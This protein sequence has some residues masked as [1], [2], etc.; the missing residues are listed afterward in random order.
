M[1]KSSFIVGISGG[2]GSGKTCFVRDLKNNLGSENICFISLDNYYLP[3][4]EQKT[5]DQGIKNFDL[6]ESIDA[7]AL[8]EDILKLM[9]G[10]TVRRQEYNFNN[11]KKD[12]SEYVLYPA[13]VFVIEGLFIYHYPELKELFDLKLFIEA[14]DTHKIVRRIKRDQTERNYPIEDV[15]YR[16]ENH[17]FPSYN[18]Y[19]KIYKPEVDLIINNNSDYKRAL[20]IVSIYIQH[21]LEG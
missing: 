14:E 2:S 18:R 5:D 13:E 10:E 17:V 8:K 6:P 9:S 11:E 7:Q 4:D 19:I 12:A 16:Y 3:R 15:L 21:K 1:E 20:D